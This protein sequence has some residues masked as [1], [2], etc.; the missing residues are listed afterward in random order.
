VTAEAPAASGSSRGKSDVTCFRCNQKGHKSPNCPSRPKGNRRVRLPAEKLLYLQANELFGQVGVHGVPITCDSGAQVSVVPD[1][2]VK[3]E[4]LT[5]ETQILEDFHTGHV[6]GKV[7]QVTFTIARRSFR[8]RA[9]T[10]PGELLR[11]TLCM[12]VPLA[13]REEME[14][15]L[16]QIGVKEAAGKEETRYLPPTLDGDLLVSGLMM[17]E[18]VVVHKKVAKTAEGVAVATEKVPEE[19]IPSSNV[20]GEETVDTSEGATGSENVVEDEVE[21]SNG[22]TEEEVVE[23]CLGEGDGEDASGY[24]EGAGETAGGSACG[25]ELMFTGM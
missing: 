9:V 22:N 25:D 12:A 20:L 5:G 13:P 4:E 14:F 19:V 21:G 17:S 10:L 15:I 7:C 1:E 18:G 3:E 11:W 23:E 2:C 24:V 8:K 6:T 16:T